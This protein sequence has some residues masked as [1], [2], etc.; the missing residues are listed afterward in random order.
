MNEL[1]PQ[2]PVRP[3]VGRDVHGRGAH[4]GDVGA[5]AAEPEF[6]L[7]ARRIDEDLDVRLVDQEFL[8]DILAVEFS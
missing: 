7:A 2:G 4:I 5:V 1:V 8:G 3:G 6:F